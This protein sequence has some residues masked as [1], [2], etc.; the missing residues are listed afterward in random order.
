[1][2]YVWEKIRNNVSFCM[3]LLLWLFELVINIVYVKKYFLVHGLDSDFAGDA[4]FA[5]HLADSGH[6]IFL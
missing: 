2:K 3:L 4:I 5:K 1:M 6:Y